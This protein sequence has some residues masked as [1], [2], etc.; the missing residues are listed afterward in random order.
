MATSDLTIDDI[1]AP[2]LVKFMQQAAAMIKMGAKG[3]LLYATKDET[4]E[5]ELVIKEYKSGLGIDKIP[6]TIKAQIKKAFLGEPNKI[7]LAT[8]KASFDEIANKLKTKKFNWFVCD[9]IDAQNDVAM[10]AKE[11]KKF[12][13]V[14]NTKAD[15]KFVVN[16]TNPT[17]TEVG[18]NVIDTIKYLPRIAGAIA[19][20]PYTMSMTGYTFTD[21]EDV[22]LPEKIEQGAFIL[23]MED[24]GVKVASAV[25]SLTTITENMSESDKKICVVE[26]QVRIEEDKKATFLS[27]YKGKMKNF[28]DNQMLWIA[29]VIGFYKQL[30]S[31]SILDPNYNNTTEIDVE[32]QR[33]AWLAKGKSEAETWDDLTVK[34][35]TIGD[36]IY[37]KSDI[38]ILDAIEGIE[39]R[40]V[41]M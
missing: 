41:L 36:M 24:D 26:A 40:I 11:T 29:A 34:K 32:A 10:F 19:G 4:Q 25:N 16:V 38:K 1:K 21:L 2:M 12:A 31:M 27:S 18:G 28:Y 37:E 6:D 30:A 15:S 35:N 8:Y 3:A 14:F 5:D 20:L 9:D 33:D 39:N 13:V 22:E 17:V 23:N 7:I